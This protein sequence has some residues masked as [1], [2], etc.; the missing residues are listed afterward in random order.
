MNNRLN[1]L[2]YDMN[3]RLHAYMKFF[4]GPLIV[5]IEQIHDDRRSS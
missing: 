3:N 5:C 1:K 2:K 4:D